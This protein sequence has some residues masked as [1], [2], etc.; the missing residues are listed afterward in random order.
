MTL[1]NSALLYLVIGGIITVFNAFHQFIPLVFGLY[2]LLL[3]LISF[4][5]NFLCQKG[6]TNYSWGLSVIAILL[7]F[8]LSFTSQGT[9]LIDKI[10]KTN[11]NKI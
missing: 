3:I 5:L 6:Y 11:R 2:L 4:M 7:L 1:C 10:T 8:Y 9:E